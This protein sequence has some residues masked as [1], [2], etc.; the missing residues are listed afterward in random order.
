MN[1]FIGLLIVMGSVLGGFAAMGGNLAVLWQ[2][3]E[4][5]MIIGAALG[6]YI[7]ANPKS[8]IRD[9]LWSVVGL[10]RGRV[11]TQEEYLELFAMLYMLF[12]QGKD[13]LHK[14]EKD[15]DDPMNSKFF[16]SFPHVSRNP[17]NVR[18][19]A[20]YFRLVL[21]DNQKSHELEAL[22]D[23]EIESIETDLYKV[24]NALLTMADSLP[25]VGIVAAVLGVI[26]AMGAI[27]EPPEVLGALIGGALVGTFLGVLLSYGFVGPLGNAVRARREQELTYYIAIKT[28]LIAHLNGYKPEIAVEYGRKT[29][30]AIDRPVFEDVEE[31]MRETALKVGMEVK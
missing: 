7:I 21:L 1:L 18:F 4:L 25:A 2:P 6:A 28:A 12:R 27:S 14:L 10:M 3:W 30:N 31:S 13:N 26:K 5:V 20:D 29:I 11:H 22:L 17:T 9:T 24:P 16:T 15:F 23:T 8:V 19:L